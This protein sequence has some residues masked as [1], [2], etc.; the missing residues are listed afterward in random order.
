MQ[1]S[2][3]HMIRCRYLGPT[4]FRGARISISWE[5]WP[6]NGN[7]VRKIVEWM[8]DEELAETAANLFVAWLSDDKDTPID[9]SRKFIAHRITIADGGP[10]EWIVFVETKCVARSAAA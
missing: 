4:N 10:V 9:P 3:A 6:T 1:V 5:G 8:K 7:R 2:S